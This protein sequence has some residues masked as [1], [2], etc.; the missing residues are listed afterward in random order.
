MNRKQRFW[1]WVILQ[2][3]NLQRFIHLHTLGEEVWV[4]GDGDANAL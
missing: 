2:L 3:A 4:S 1:Y